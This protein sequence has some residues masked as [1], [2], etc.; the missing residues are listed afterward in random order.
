MKLH[1]TIAD[2]ETTDLTLDV[3]EG[4]LVGDIATVIA[5]EIASENTSDFGGTYT[6]GIVGGSV[7]DAAT[8]VLRSGLRSGQ[9][10][11]LH[12]RTSPSTQGSPS[13][14]HAGGTLVGAALE[15]V[16]GGNVLSPGLRFRLQPGENIVGRGGA[17][18]V[19]IEHAS[20]SR[21]HF[22]I[23]VGEDVQLVDLQSVNGVLVNG[24]RVSASVRLTDGAVIQAGD[25]SLRFTDGSSGVAPGT[26]TQAALPAVTYF[27]RPPRTQP[28]YPGK[29]FTAP[30]PP[31][32]PDREPFMWVPAAV[33]LLMAGLLLM[34]ST[35]NLGTALAFGLMSPLMLAGTWWQ[36]R[37]NQAKKYE[38][39]LREYRVD[40]ADLEQS[41]LLEQE[42]E[43]SVR[44]LQA[45][46]TPVL[47][48]K[49][50]S[51]EPDLWIRSVDTVGQP[52]DDFLVVRIA[53]GDQPSVVTVNIP[54]GGERSERAA[55]ENLPTRVGTVTDVPVEADL[56]LGGL[57]V[58]GGPASSRA[59][60]RSALSQLAA[61][62]S[63][64][65][66]A[67]AAILSEEEAP[68]W[69]WLK[70][71]PHT[72]S[73]L[74]PLDGE[75][76]AAT[77]AACVDLLRRLSDLAESRSGES[78]DGTFASWIVLLIDDR[79]RLDRPVL[80]ALLR[81]GA[82]V[83][84]SF[85][86]LAQEMSDLP[87][88]CHSVVSVDPVMPVLRLNI[89]G[90]GEIQQGLRA[91]L[92]S[93]DQ[94][95][96]FGRGLA[97]IQ[98][99]SARIA[100]E[101]DLPAVVLLSEMLGGE[102]V[103]SDP[104][105]IQARWT[106]AK[107]KHRTLLAPIGQAP[108]EEYGVD[109]VQ[110]GPHGF[111]IGTTGSGKSELLRTLLI[112]LAATFPPDRVNFLLVD[113]K[114]GA[115]LKPFLD[116][117]HTVG[118]VTNLAEGEQHAEL[119][120][121]IKVK[122]T[123]VWLRA[124]LQRRMSVLNEA[125]VS[126]IVDLER[127]HDGS[128]PPRLLIVADEFAV[129]ANNR[130]SAGEDVIDEIV[131]VARL[132]RSLGIHLLLATQRAAGVITDN[133]RA[134]TNLRIALR[135]QGA[136]ESNDVVGS[137][138]AAAISLA[139]PG[140]AFVSIGSGK[141][142]QVQTAS[143]TG[144][145]AALLHRPKVR[146]ERFGFLGRTPAPALPLTLP[147]APGDNDLTKLVNVIGEAS[148]GWPVPVP[149]AHW[150][151]PPA[152]IVPL[153]S[154]ERAEDPAVVAF[155][156]TDDP[157]NQQV[158]VASVNLRTVGS[159][160][161][162]GTGRSGKT[163]FLRTFAAAMALRS[164]PEDVRLY[165]VD[166]AGRG[167]DVLAALPNV[168]ETV[169]SDDIEMVHRLFRELRR[170]IDRRL[171][172][173]ADLGVSDLT[174]YRDRYPDGEDRHL[175]VVL[176]DNL[177]NFVERFGNVDGG[178]LVDRLPALLAQGRTAGVHFVIT[179]N[180]RGGIPM[181]VASVISE[182]IVLRMANVDEYGMLNVKTSL[183]PIDPPPGRGLYRGLI[184]QTAI[185]TSAAHAE[186]V[187]AALGSHDDD[188]LAAVIEAAGQGDQQ[189]TAIL[190]VGA[191]LQT[192]GWITPARFGI[193]RLPELMPMPR[194]HATGEL[195]SADLGL[196]DSTLAPAGL[197]IAES[198]FLI[199]GP[200]RSG[201]STALRVLVEQLA[202]STPGLQ[203]HLICPRRSIATESQV[204]ASISSTEVD[205]V[206]VIGQLTELVRSNEL[207]HPVVLC[208][209]DYSD[210]DDNQ[211]GGPFSSLLN[212]S[213]RG[214][215]VRFVV[216][217][218]ARGLMSIW[219]DGVKGVRRYRTGLLLQPDPDADGDLLSAR[220]PRQAWRAFPPGRG[221]LVQG[222]SVE[223]IQSWYPGDAPH[224]GR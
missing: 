60:V 75:H 35:G 164:K 135:V 213:K 200:P 59:S 217:G 222:T 146:A 40:V 186:V 92:L 93:A 86:W 85:I 159:L 99:I 72:R 81:R 129:L 22:R 106:E 10:V 163:V 120:L 204:W 155:G 53:Q 220:L 192:N 56:K 7:L 103:L 98:D 33:P 18:T 154:V 91:D 17:A 168:A 67:I 28:R 115:A 57:G 80:D 177:N 148:Q 184:V 26:L 38:R 119:K 16:N 171:Q 216:A 149:D 9:T 206:E 113:F 128:A 100:G 88:L 87:R 111:L 147:S 182:Q 130:S 107:S 223:L 73:P 84:L 143:S 36:S 165:T 11:R 132:G 144:H 21:L 54:D 137:A 4:A 12:R 5:S 29:S 157:A 153:S 48:N 97:P 141:L 105:P 50:L 183:I 25:V 199:A 83:G 140:R 24:Q 185:V 131:N 138:A 172:R 71:L 162:F 70:W 152:D 6:V 150:A 208:F 201:R 112:S 121:E 173:F 45:P 15:I 190:E 145:T 181:A 61:L 101:L 174:E 156:V 127:R 118:L 2:E 167:L 89:S 219:S 134:N 82:T 215:P 62:H 32:Y 30:I 205:G 13:T 203:A 78:D 46:P 76:L 44:R 68:G 218:E 90:S 210:L 1:L 161:V 175:A 104:T 49:V 126:D 195:W 43:A 189:Q 51:L 191:T 136:D 202:A 102:Q 23:V 8:P 209:D 55:I 176:L 116:L 110:H 94:A 63:P 178:V 41:I 198:Q 214:A 188:Q 211:I 74:S 160:A 20:V 42:T 122:R 108:G 207:R 3:E 224:T 221:Y 95:M 19:V 180:R 27:N 142:T 64:A 139:H 212:A 166:A 158:T 179:A 125:G 197:S 58:A 194:A 114:G 65:E 37:K 52:G 31:S 77:P 79:A 69:D 196:S 66:V 123:I 96:A 124:E 151:E 169:N 14:Q 170:T 117:P 133:I 193:G 34:T 39:K 109:I 47:I 187:A